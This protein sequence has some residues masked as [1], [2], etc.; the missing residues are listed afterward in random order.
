MAS[1]A[2]LFLQKVL[3]DPLLAPYFKHID[4]EKPIKMVGGECSYWPVACAC[5]RAL[6][7]GSRALPQLWQ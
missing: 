6:W 2:S 4:P 7:E 3:T 5:A 1:G